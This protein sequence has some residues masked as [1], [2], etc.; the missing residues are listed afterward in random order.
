LGRALFIG[1]PNGFNHFYDLFQASL[2]QDGWSGFEFKKE[3]G[4]I[5]ALEEL[6]SARQELD[7]RTFRQEYQ[8]RFENLGVGRAYYGFDRAHNV[9]P[10]RYNSAFPLFWS[11]D[12]NWNSLCAVLGQIVD[13]RVR[14]LDEMILPTRIRRLHV[15]SF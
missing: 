14:V 11:L 1:T 8:A 15:K 5:V 10:L 3:Q 4:R 6:E 12:F 13:G 7:A 9:R 2:E